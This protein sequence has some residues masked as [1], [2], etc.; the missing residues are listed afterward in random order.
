MLDLVREAVTA[1]QAETAAYP[2][3]VQVWMKL[4]GFSFLASI[5]FV[6][7]RVGARWILAALLLNVLGLVT[8][9]LL[10]PE[11]SRMVIGTYVHILFWPAML[12]GVWRSAKP[13][14]LSRA[15]NGL[16]DWAYMAWLAWASV[17]IAISLVLDFGNLI[18]MWV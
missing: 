6:Y 18:A 17:L 16:A 15:A 1:L 12:W 5:V 7:S 4:M 11:A 9:K 13:L 3:G 2:Q 10:F 8:G 14:L